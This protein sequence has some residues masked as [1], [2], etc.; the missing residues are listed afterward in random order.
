MASDTKIIFSKKC[1][2]YETPGHPESPERVKSTYEYLGAQGFIFIEP[3]PAKEED[4]LSVHTRQL[5][6]QVKKTDFFDADTPALPGIFDYATFSAAA[7]IKAM[8][9]GL[10]REPA[11]SL[12]RPPGHHAGKNFLGG[13]CY[14]NN[15][16]IAV[17]KAVSLGRRVAI[18][19]IDCHHGNGTQDIFLGNINVLYVSLHQVPLYPGTGLKSDLNCLNYPLRPGTG[20]KEYLDTL[21]EAIREIE[22][23]SPDL[24]A[25]SAGFDTYKDD[26]LT[27]IGLDVESYRRIKELIIESKFPYFSVLEGGYCP[28]LKYC[29]YEFL[30]L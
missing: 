16:A 19:D 27:D 23:F 1:L 22:K 4:I 18:L 14:F 24:L 29:I 21:K 15:I 28:E 10:K 5:V 7:A 12:F 6:E 3:E 30:K 13:F 26:P 8:E 17:E 9:L 2:E 25:I 20:E 11:F